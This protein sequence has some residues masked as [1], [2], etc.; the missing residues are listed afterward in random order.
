MSSKLGSVVSMSVAAL[1]VGEAAC[2][3][4]ADGGRAASASGC[5]GAMPPGL[6]APAGHKLA[7][8]L[9]ADGVQIYACA[10]PSG[11]AGPAWVL[12]APEAT[13]VDGRGVFAG[14]HRAGPTW[15]ALDGST[16]LGAK[17]ATGPSD[18]AA[19]PWL[20]LRAASH[21]ADRGRMADVTFVQRTQTSGG[22]APSE[23]CS[24]ATVG[25]VV[26]VPYH[27]VYCF[28]RREGPDGESAMPSYGSPRP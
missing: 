17:V 10:D 27:A 1:M 18:P 28:F 23:G 26:R 3:A 24:G 22:V 20:L 13:L 7:F 8:E 11:A 12:Q 5:S 16:V 21:G 2:A 14:T 6:A 9:L 19:I 25:T 15:E 4:S